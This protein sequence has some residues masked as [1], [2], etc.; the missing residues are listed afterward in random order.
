MV[1][2]ENDLYYTVKNQT[3]GKSGLLI[4]Y[5]NININNIQEHLIL[6]LPLAIINFKSR[7]NN[8]N[9]NFQTFNY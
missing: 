7:S 4:S 8:N 3:I 2:F 5:L 6:K 9:T 1:N